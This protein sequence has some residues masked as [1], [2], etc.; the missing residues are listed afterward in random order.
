MCEAAAV[1]IG[2]EIE[3]F[4][5]GDAG[6]I[7]AAFASLVGKAVRGLAGQP[8]QLF[9]GNR[10]QI[11]ALAAQH[12]VPALYFEREFAHVG[13]LMSY[14]PTSRSSI[15]NSASMRAAFSAAK[16]LAIYR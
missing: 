13:G 9:F 7:D 15:A 14:G 8:Q 11:V 6:D 16:S 3:V 12:R 1:A 2:Q 10:M 4:Y 5:A